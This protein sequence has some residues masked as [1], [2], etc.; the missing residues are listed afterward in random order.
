MDEPEMK[1]VASIL[2]EVLRKPDDEG[3][4]DEARSRVRELVTRFPAYP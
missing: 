1:E 4:K 3:V 2:G